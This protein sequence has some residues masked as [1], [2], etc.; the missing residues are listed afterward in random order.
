MTIKSGVE[1]IY[2]LNEINPSGQ[3]EKTDKAEKFLFKGCLKMIGSVSLLILLQL[4]RLFKPMFKLVM[5]MY[6]LASK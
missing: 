1:E 4:F 5:F 3:D 6:D 2:K